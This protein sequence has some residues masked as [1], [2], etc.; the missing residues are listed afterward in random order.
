MKLQFPE[1]WL[2]AEDRPVDHVEEIEVRTLTS[3]P[4]EYFFAAVPNVY[5]YEYDSSGKPRK[6]IY[7]ENSYAV[8]LTPSL[9]VRAST[10][11]EWESA[12]QIATAGRPV[13]S[14]GPDL[15]SGE[16]DYRGKKFQKTGKYW[17]SATVSPGGKWLAIFSYTGERTRDLVFM[18]G[19]SVKSGDIFWDVYDTETGKKVFERRARDVRNPTVFGGPV[20]WLEERYFL[21]P[22]DE[23]EQNLIIV[24]LP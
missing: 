10:K 2:E 12:K 16:I 8:R 24:I 9:R 15:S 1:P 23:T 17:Q 22:E 18:D 13:Y 11:Q 3:S 20:V 21:F 6:L 4:G 14:N 19:G 5:A 7:S